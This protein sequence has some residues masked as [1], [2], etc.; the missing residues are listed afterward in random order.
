M[1]IGVPKETK[2][3]ESRVGLT[4]KYV[5]KLVDQGHSVVIQKNLAEVAGI[6]DDEY[7]AAGASVV[8]TMNEVYDAAQ[9]IVK[10][11]DYI[12]GE[13]DVPIRKDH[14]IWC[15]FHLGEN[16]PD[17]KITKKMV[18]AKAAGLAYEMLQ[19][20]DGTRPI[21]VP[22]SEIAGRMTTITAAT[23]CTLPNG[24]HGICPT[25]ITGSRRPK[26]VIIGGGHAGYAAA[27]IAERFDADVTVF[28]AFQSRRLFLRDNLPKS[29]ILTYDVDEINKYALDCDVLI[30][31]LY[32]YPGMVVPVIPRE[33]VK[34][35]RKGTVIMDMAGTNI[36]E[37][38]HY[39]TISDPYYIDEGVVHYCVDNIPALVPETSMEACM[40]ITYPFIEA[41]ANKGLKKA[42]E[43]NYEMRKA[44][45]FY[46]G[47]IVNKDVGETH[48]M[49]WVEFDP[50]MIKE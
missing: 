45:N 42:C 36:I 13:Y 25:A 16:E 15:F 44:I 22:M 49:P 38:I 7:I 39:T 32:P 20:P 23:L 21:M 41:I 10:F 19:T 17:F 27:Q 6:S 43:E 1:I 9:M 35:M 30:N 26:Y 24:G 3:Q 48:D 47:Q 2:D 50:A 34:K 4:P 40:Q 31:A 18:E 5:K 28:E 11:K 33:T 46:N 14:I 37:T 8:E 29:E 12:E